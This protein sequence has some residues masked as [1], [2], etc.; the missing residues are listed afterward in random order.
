MCDC[1]RAECE[2]CGRGID[3]HIGDFSTDRENV[4]VFC[5]NCSKE[6]SEHVLGSFL[7]EEGTI[8]KQLT[9]CEGQVEGFG[10]GKMVII[11]VN[12]RKGHSIH[13]N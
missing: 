1:Y 5:P 3:M 6:V 13:L 4:T 2:L 7:E 8:I 9:E 10:K 11:V 12:G